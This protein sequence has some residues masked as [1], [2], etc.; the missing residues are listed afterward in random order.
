MNNIGKYEN[1]IDGDYR[2]E[3]GIIQYYDGECYHIAIAGDTSSLPVFLR[4][5]FRIVRNQDRMKNLVM[6]R[7]E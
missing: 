7:R 5:E 1:I 4:N 3:W 2:G 6:G